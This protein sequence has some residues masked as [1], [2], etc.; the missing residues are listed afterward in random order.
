MPSRRLTSPEIAK[1]DEL[2]RRV[3]AD[4]TALADGDGFLL[5]AL[6]RRLYARLMHMERETPAD[7]N[8]LKAEKRKD[9]GG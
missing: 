6:R 4:L 8:K 2:K 7:R 9:R 1:L 5:S 3:V